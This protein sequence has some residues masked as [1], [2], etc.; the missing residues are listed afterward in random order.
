MLE[1]HRSHLWANLWTRDQLDLLRKIRARFSEWHCTPLPL[2]LL[3]CSYI[4]WILSTICCS[5]TRQLSSALIT[6]SQRTAV[7]IPYMRLPML[8]TIHH[9]FICLFFRRSQKWWNW[10]AFQCPRPWTWDKTHAVYISSDPFPP[11]AKSTFCWYNPSVRKYTAFRR[12]KNVMWVPRV[13]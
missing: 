13:T 11:A 5:R 3:L 6:L 4:R 7:A 12:K 9:A 8:P 2:P 1:K 10:P